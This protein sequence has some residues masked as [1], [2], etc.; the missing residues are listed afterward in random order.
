[1][2]TFSFSP[3]F[4]SRCLSSASIVGPSEEK[5]ALDKNFEELWLDPC[6]AHNLVIKYRFYPL[7]RVISKSVKI[8]E[9][10]F[11]CQ[12]EKLKE[13]ERKERQRVEKKREEKELQE[14]ERQERIEKERTKHEKE[15]EER[16][17]RER[18]ERK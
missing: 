12:E 6:N 16:I 18:E 5:I 1:M 9:N 10:V 11:Y 4:R 15:E 2:S 3:I 17:D 13:R 7:E 14:K 8:Y